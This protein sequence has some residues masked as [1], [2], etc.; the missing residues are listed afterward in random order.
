MASLVALEAARSKEVARVGAGATAR[1]R[2]HCFFLLFFLYPLI[3][4]CASLPKIKKCQV[5]L[6]LCQIWSLFF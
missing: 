5:I 6:F 1:I 2:K 3:R 4:I